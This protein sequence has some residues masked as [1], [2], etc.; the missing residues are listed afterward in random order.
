M[1]T[2]AV[3]KTGKYIS[4]IVMILSS[5]AIIITGMH[6]YLSEN[7]WGAVIIAFGVFITAVR[8]YLKDKYG[9]M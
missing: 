1:E 6:S 9:M 7:D 5:I 2:T 4:L 8:N 3:L